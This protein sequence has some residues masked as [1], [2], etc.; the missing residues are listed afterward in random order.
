MTL[1]VKS[2]L[3]PFTL[4]K[5]IVIIGETA[6]EQFITVKSFGRDSMPEN[7]DEEKVFTIKN[8]K[9]NKVY[10]SDLNNS[11][12]GIEIYFTTLTTIEVV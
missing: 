9:V 8:F 3:G 5:L 1:R 2:A 10:N 7:F 11:D 12:F 6:D 4:S